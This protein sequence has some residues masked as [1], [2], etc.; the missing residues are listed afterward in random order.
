MNKTKFFFILFVSWLVI[1]GWFVIARFSQSHA[2]Q[3]PEDI[4]V[5]WEML[6]RINGQ[7]ETRQ[8][9]KFSNHS[10]AAHSGPI[11]RF[12]PMTRAETEQE[13]KTFLEKAKTIEE[14]GQEMSKDSEKQLPPG[15]V[16]I[17]P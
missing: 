15:E 2:T 12:Q 14:V 4:E 6:E 5:D 7:G 10:S 1:I 13:Y 3:T 11:K 17:K 8:E 9:K 16:E